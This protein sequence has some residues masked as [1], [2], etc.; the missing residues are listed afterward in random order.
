MPSLVDVSGIRVGHAGDLSGLTGC[1][2]VLCEAGAVG[3]AEIRGAAPGTRE[4]S[5]LVPGALVGRIHAVVLAGG[6]AFGLAA[7]DG[8]MRYLEAR[9]VGFN[10]GVARVPIVTGAVLFDLAVGDS[11]S[12]PDAAMGYEACTRAT[13]DPVEEGCVGAGT[14]ATV[15]KAFGLGSA[16][17]GGLGSWAVRLEDGPTVGAMAVVN[18][19]GDVVD[20][21]TGE[22]LAGARGPDGT[23][24]RTADALLARPPQTALGTST[25]LVVI[26]TDAA[27]NRGQA[28]RLAIQGHAGLSRSIV[29]S[30]TMY[31]G[32]VVFVLA[33]AA[34][35]GVR[36][37]ADLVRLGE[38]AA[39]VT[40]EAVKRA[41]R[42]AWSLGGIPALT[43]PQP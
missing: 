32:D 3:A 22:V 8:V 37:A 11:R 40:A 21:R 25:T 14:G 10:V 13:A 6:S 31:D 15:G 9:G 38:I 5:L 23:L 28:L 39:A 4:T 43:D 41:V 33:T 20:S 17:K 19:F 7:A 26:A 24:L 34:H 35:A 30:H 12:R 29:P 27:L 16:M 42:T 1:T 18:A 2:V 36:G